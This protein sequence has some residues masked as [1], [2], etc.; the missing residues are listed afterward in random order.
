MTATDTTPAPKRE[1]TEAQ[2]RV[3]DHDQ[4]G[5]AGGSKPKAGEVLKKGAAP[6]AEA[7]S[8]KAADLVL[9]RIAKSGHGLVHDGQGGTYSWQDEVMLPY[10]VAAAQE[11]NKNVEIIG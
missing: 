1:L 3:L 2:V 5:R 9:V 6:P 4:D 10:A 8:H 11:A 7:A